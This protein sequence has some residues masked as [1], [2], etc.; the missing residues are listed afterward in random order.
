M[1]FQLATKLTLTGPLC[2]DHQRAGCDGRD[3]RELMFDALGH[4]NLVPA[5]LNVP[6]NEDT[7]HHNHVHSPK[8]FAIS[9]SVE[10]YKVFLCRAESLKAARNRAKMSRI[11]YASHQA[12]ACPTPKSPHTPPTQSYIYIPAHR[13]Q[14]SRPVAQDPFRNT[15][16]TQVLGG[17]C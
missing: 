12:R 16:A 10:L 8:Y 6:E 4:P 14:V 5:L 13:F 9:K 3:L 11:V 7:F 15:L 17:R 2:G 1:E